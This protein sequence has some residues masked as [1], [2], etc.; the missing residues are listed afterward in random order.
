MI[1]E[2]I[3]NYCKSLDIPVEAKLF[4]T[5]RHIGPGISG[6]FSLNFGYQYA[7]VNVK[8]EFGKFR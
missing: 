3:Y 2:W 1:P 6:F 4:L 8:L 5:S 7:R